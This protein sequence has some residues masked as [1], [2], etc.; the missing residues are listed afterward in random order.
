MEIAEVNSTNVGRIAERIVASELEYRGFRVTD[1]NKEGTSANADLLAAR[2]ER[3][4]QIQVKGASQKT[5]KKGWEHWWVQYGYCKQEQ[6]LKAQR[7]FN[8]TTGFYTAQFV[9][10]AAVRTPREYCCL[11]LPVK[12]AEDLAQINLDREFRTPTFK[13]TPHK[14]H[15]VWIYLDHV[16]KMRIQER[17]PSFKEEARMLQRF[18]DNWGV[19]DVAEPEA[20][21]TTAAGSR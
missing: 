9:I 3:T 21:L 1:L 12:L 17:L 6:I 8:R 11:V 7:M 20:A 5:T 14:P 2:G 19:L 13:G 18:R 10:L 15:K 16:P 4:L